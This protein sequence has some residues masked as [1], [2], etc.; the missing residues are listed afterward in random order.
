[1]PLENPGLA[2][3]A[4]LYVLAGLNHFRS[5]G[6]YRPMM[7]PWIPAH[8]AMIFLSGIAEIV[9]GISLMFEATRS[10]A[11][12]GIILL[13]IAVMPVH[14]YMLQERTKKFARLPAIVLWLRL[15]LQALLIAWAA[16]YI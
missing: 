16:L 1:M 7:P 11:A 4:L 10:L 6:F 2:L 5:P 13:L 12:I 9:L 3:M 14:I 15:P 8:D